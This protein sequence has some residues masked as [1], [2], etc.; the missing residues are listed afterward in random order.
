MGDER[1]E[2]PALPKTLGARQ[3][4][5]I[6]DAGSAEWSRLRG[7]QYS[8]LTRYTIPRI[9]LHAL[10]AA[11]TL[12]I[13][14]IMVPLAALIGWFAALGGALVAGIALDTS[15]ADAE[16]RSMKQ[17]EFIRQGM[18]AGVIAA[19]WAVA[20]LC[21]PS[22]AGG[23]ERLALWS[24]V[25]LLILS[26]S[27]SP[28][29]APFNTVI[30]ALIV[31]AAGALSFTLGGQY[32]L[33]VFAMIYTGIAVF[34]TVRVA[35]TYLVARTAEAGMAEKSEVVSMLLREFEESEADWLWQVDTARRVRSASPR[36][37]FALGRDPAK[38]DGVSFIELIAGD[39][40]ESGQF[41]PS[42]HDL[43]ERL[44]HRDSFANVLVEVSVGK[45][46]RWWEISGSPII[47]DNGVF[48]GFRG[49][50][51]DVTEKRESSEKIAY[52]ARYDTLTGLPNRLMLTDSLG[53]AMR[54]ALQWRTRCAFL[55]IDLDRFKAVN[56]SLG[57]MVGDRLLA[58]VSE[59]LS[60]ICTEN[61]LV[62]R[63]GGDEFAVVIRD[64]SERGAVDRVAKRL[65]ARLS[66]PYVV[67]NNTLFVG[68]SVGSACGPRDGATVEE[69]MRNADLALYRAKDEGGGNHFKY[70][71]AL[72]ASAEE[73]RK[74]EFSLRNALDSNEFV[75]HYQP[76]V[77]A[78]S[79]RIVS[80]EAL[81]RWNSK[82]HGL[83]S[84]AKFVPLAE[85]TRLI[86]PI[87]EWVLREACREAT[88]WP[89][90]VKVAVNVSGE[91]LLEPD[92]S[93]TVV[94]ALAQ[95]GL[96][97]SRL[98]I[99][100]TESIFLRDA[101]AARTALQS[102]MALG[103]AIALDD[104]GT[105]YSSLGYLR[106]L[107]FSTIKVDRSFVQGAAQGSRESLAIIR[108]VVAMADSLEM[109]TTAEGVETA[110]EVQLIRQLGCK[111]IQGYYF[112]RPMESADARALFAAPAR[113]SA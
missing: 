110:A 7:F 109:S 107:Q 61:E 1:S 9:A 94:S 24:L 14:Q 11:M 89:A 41:P 4:L 42:L 2:L 45:A 20:L 26:A 64:A 78:T 112:G 100:V 53:E 46:K 30:F 18:S 77:D 82:E 35:R 50:G 97:A 71:P 36:F 96:P 23:G 72:H 101:S 68:A 86:V 80:F 27:M 98:E 87:G 55:M 25:A 43:A 51:S 69:L 60:E 104:F 85:D 70:E 15:L 103:C 13:F 113:V 84:P 99:E 90:A 32:E 67:D 48:S 95:S 10:A 22:V 12:R 31:G 3:V 5:G 40:W 59:R 44:K 108:A 93:D 83:V 34:G 19:M 21:F 16:R 58:Q 92:F 62:G 74:L 111:K 75:L 8:Q 106:K 105:G 39:A 54:Y 37:A 52:L 76:V 29:S 81:V 91:Q 66:Q 47:G 63:L 65:I 6:A 56:D 57:H 38:V 102:L 79:Q 33:A 49:V 17:R 88:L 28:A 73:R